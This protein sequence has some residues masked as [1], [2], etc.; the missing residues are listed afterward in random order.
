MQIRPINEL[1]IGGTFP[2][3]LYRLKEII[4][5]DGFE[6][7]EDYRLCDGAVESVTIPT[8]VR[9][10]CAH[11]FYNCRKLKNVTFK[12]SGKKLPSAVPRSELRMIG[13]EAFCGCDSLRT[14]LLPDGLEDIGLRAFRKSGLENIVVP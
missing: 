10:I 8:S 9:E 4:I 14:I 12:G 13:D 1:M 2:W 7:V 5:P 6:K 3:E 11:A